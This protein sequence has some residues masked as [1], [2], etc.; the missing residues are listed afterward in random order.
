MFS[1]Q[2]SKEVLRGSI[3]RSPIIPPLTNHF[4]WNPRCGTLFQPQSDPFDIWTP[5]HTY[6]GT[7]QV[8]VRHHDCGQTVWWE[9]M[10]E[11]RT[12]WYV[13]RG[14]SN[15]CHHH[16]HCDQ[17]AISWRVSTLCLTGC[18]YRSP[19]FRKKVD[20]IV[21]EKESMIEQPTHK[22]TYKQIDVTQ[23]YVI[24]HFDVG[25]AF[26]TFL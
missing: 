18:R 12:G 1:N 11:Y 21:A 22:Q 15:D 3:K 16:H 20:S 7:H 23:F 13:W 10:Q 19:Y 14:R 24:P 5:T 9:K 8:E 4:R 6:R 17:T 26:Q 25:R 2:A